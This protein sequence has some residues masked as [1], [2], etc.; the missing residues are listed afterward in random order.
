VRIDAATAKG[1]RIEQFKDVFERAISGRLPSEQD[2]IFPGQGKTRS[3]H[4]VTTIGFW[5]FLPM[6][7]RH[8]GVTRP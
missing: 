2:H 6:S 4:N 3:R 7:S 1:Y 5:P 8:N